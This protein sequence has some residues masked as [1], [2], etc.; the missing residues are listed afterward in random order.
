MA[1]AP[2]AARICLAA[3][4]RASHQLPPRAQ[5]LARTTKQRMPQQ[6]QLRALS[7]TIPRNARKRDEDAEDDITKEELQQKLAEI[8]KE[9]MEAVSPE[10]RR[11]MDEFVQL[12]GYKSYSHYVQSVFEKPKTLQE[13]RALQDELS[14]DIMGERPNR[15]SFWYDED[16]PESYTEEHEEFN[17]DDITSMAHGK[18]DEIREMRHYARLAVWEMPLLASK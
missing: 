16:D 1:T 7:S 12:D 18:L 6:Q 2:S 4:R 14:K 13:D 17:E 5:Y 11:A 8:D 10:H 3:C 15:N 9:S